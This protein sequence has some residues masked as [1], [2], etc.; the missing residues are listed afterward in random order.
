MTGEVSTEIYISLEAGAGRGVKSGSARN[1]AKF[2]AK[3]EEGTEVG[4][5]A[6]RSSKIMVGYISRPVEVV[7]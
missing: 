1:G 2:K 4:W 5:W 6:F 7:P 3:T